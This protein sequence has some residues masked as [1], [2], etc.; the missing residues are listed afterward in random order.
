M[1]SMKSVIVGKGIAPEETAIASMT[2]SG[3][4][5]D[6]E[7]QVDQILVPLPLIAQS[8]PRVGKD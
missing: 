7:K 3:A 8:R 1:N 6:V 4:R 2:K 5:N